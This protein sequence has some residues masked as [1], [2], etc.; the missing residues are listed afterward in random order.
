MKKLNVFG[1]LAMF[2]C[3][4]CSIL[5]PYYENVECRKGENGGKCIDVQ[6]AYADAVYTEAEDNMPVPPPGVDLEKWEKQ[7]EISNSAKTY[8]ESVYKQITNLIEAP[9]T[10]ILTPPKILRVLVRPYEGNDN[11]LYMQNYVFIQV[12]EGHWILSGGLRE[13]KN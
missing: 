4:G 11:E 13:V 6:T 3:S 2:L 8:Q 5:N 7:Q 1:F 10:P 12:D 9:E